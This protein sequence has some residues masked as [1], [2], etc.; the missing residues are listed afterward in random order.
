MEHSGTTGNY[1][2]GTYTFRD[3][4]ILFGEFDCL[5]FFF[6]RSNEM[7][8]NIGFLN[9][10]DCIR[11]MRRL[12]HIMTY[13]HI[14]VYLWSVSVFGHKHTRNELCQDTSQGAISR[15]CDIL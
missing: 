8:G 4:S 9:D 5:G 7:S 10:W 14:L 11:E 6:F 12:V 15:I 13:S 1:I 2:H 3:F